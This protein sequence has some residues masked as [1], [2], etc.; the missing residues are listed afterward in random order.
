MPYVDAF[1]VAVPKES[2][3]AYKATA[4]IAGKIWK[5]FGALAYLECIGDDVPYGALTFFP[6][7]VQ[8]KDNEIIAFSRIVYESRERREFDKR[9]G[10]CRPLNARQHVGASLRR[11][12]P[13]PRRVRDVPGAVAS[14]SRALSKR[15]SMGRYCARRFQTNSGFFPDGRWRQALRQRMQSA[16]RAVFTALPDELLVCNETQWR[17]LARV[18][19]SLRPGRCGPGSSVWN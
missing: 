9:K 8:A 13:D 12:A 6:R 10:D 1:V 2:L 14:P 16:K 11:Q 5:K 19:R 3:E 4:R 15:G 17:T 7:A 18:L